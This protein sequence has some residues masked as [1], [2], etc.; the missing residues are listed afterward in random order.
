MT[1]LHHPTLHFLEVKYQSKHV[2]FTAVI[3]ANFT[4]NTFSVNR[5]DKIVFVSYHLAKLFLRLSSH[6]QKY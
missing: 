4:V 3:V 6:L 1:K 2:C 5:S